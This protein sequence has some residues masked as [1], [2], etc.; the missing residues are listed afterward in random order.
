MSLT[1]APN[2][3]DESKPPSLRER[4]GRDK[5][6]RRGQAGS[7]KIQFS[8][9][10]SL[11]ARR[12]DVPN[13]HCRGGYFRAHEKAPFPDGEPALR[14]GRLH[15]SRARNDQSPLART[16]SE[17]LISTGEGKISLDRHRQKIEKSPIGGIGG[18]ICQ[19]GRLRTMRT[20]FP[21]VKDFQERRSGDFG[22]EWW[23]QQISQKNANF[24]LQLP[25]VVC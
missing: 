5:V 17:L 22:E 6:G 7:G 8:P 21:I 13:F 15:F 16:S 9:A 1:G 2:E 25:R 10:L 12:G 11:R 14:R 19:L 24:A 3:S 23:R 20:N 18:D 4:A